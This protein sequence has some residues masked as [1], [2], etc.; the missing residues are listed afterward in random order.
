MLSSET[1]ALTLTCHQPNFICH[2]TPVSCECQ[3]VLINV[4][5]VFSRATG[6]QVFAFD[7]RNANMSISDSYTAA[8]SDIS[9]T[10]ITS[11]LTSKLNFS[12]SESVE[13]QCVDNNQ[14][15]P[16]SV[17]LQMASMLVTP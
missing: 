15:D 6:F 12:I 1:E 13:V 4:W 3:G 2:G 14:P 11:V 16:A 10:G 9:G 17:T 8:L 5:K 7:T